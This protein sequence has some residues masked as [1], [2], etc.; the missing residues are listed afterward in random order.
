MTMC[1][2]ACHAPPKPP[3]PPQPCTCCPCCEHERP[4]PPHCTPDPNPQ[5]PGTVDVPQPTPPPNFGG[6]PPQKPPEGDPSEIP[7]VNGQLGTI[8]RKG[9][10]FGK[11]VDEYLPLL[12]V[13]ANAGDMGARALDG[14]FWESPDIFV[15]PDVDPDSAP[16]VPAN[17][18]GVAKAN[19]SNTVYAHV[20]N[21]GRAQAY[22]ARVEFY[23]FNPSLGIARADS[24]FIGS[25]WV[26]LES[27]YVLYPQWRDVDEGFAQYATRGCHA[28]VKC[29]IDWIPTF[30]NNGHECLVVRV[31][32][33]IMDSLSPDEFSAARDRHVA[34][35]NIA[36]VLSASPAQVDLRLDLGRPPHP[37]EAEIEVL[38]AAPATM[39]WLKLY[40]NSQT[41][42][43]KQAASEVVAGF[44]PPTIRNAP[45]LHLDDVAFDCRK[46]LLRRRE[47]FHRTCE[48][49]QMT[50]HASSEHLEKGEAQILRLRQ[51]LDGEVLGGYTVVLLGH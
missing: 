1:R 15:L 36:V 51:T 41:M 50:F 13:R 9:P 8:L 19:A 11:R 28:I 43:L 47:R 10:V 12:V 7:W 2:C 22:R 30:E 46:P 27:R 3:P 21:L 40:T 48:P 44:F 29:P 34:Q 31:F 5:H 49:L 26:T 6:T 32:E 16:L 24:N 35:R 23:W 38:A 14:V 39:E 33:P 17:A 4:A 18:G 42:E 45:T 20:W 37:G 25:A